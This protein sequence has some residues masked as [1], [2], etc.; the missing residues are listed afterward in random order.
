MH[1]LLQS[2]LRLVSVLFG[3]SVLVFLI[4]HAIPGD[5]AVIA[6]GLEASP[7]TVAR[8][9]RDLGLDQPLP[10]QFVRFVTRAVTGDLGTSIRTG[11]PVV[12]EIRER[13]PHTVILT[14]EIGRAHV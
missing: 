4:V 5:P 6:A 7:E 9:R 2:F 10:V 1:L 13:L 14:L 11:V 3:I 8:I 12:S